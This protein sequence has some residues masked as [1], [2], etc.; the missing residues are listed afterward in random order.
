M[1][2]YDE[3]K[4]SE[5]E[6]VMANLAEYINEKA[7]KCSVHAE[8]WEEAVR[9]AGALLLENGTIKESY[10]ERCV[11]TVKDEGPYMVLTKGIALAH[12]RPGDDVL[13]EAIGVVSLKT[14]VEFGHKEN[15]PVKLVFLLAA[16]NANSHITVLME[17]AQKLSEGDMRERL[18]HIDDAKDLYDHLVK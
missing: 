14:P 13:E 2:Y 11:E 15:D 18:Q 16:L 9:A 6:D 5:G 4:M 17:L 7:V 8:N 1:L 12:T 10:I 3:E